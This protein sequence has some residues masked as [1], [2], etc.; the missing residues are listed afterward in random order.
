VASRD[1]HVYAVDRETG[2]VR[3]QIEGKQVAAATADTA[4]VYVSGDVVAVDAAGNE[5]KSSAVPICLVSRG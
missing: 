3:W 5:T 2:T 1:G 4:F